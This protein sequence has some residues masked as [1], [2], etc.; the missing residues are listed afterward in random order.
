MFFSSIWILEFI[1][2]SAKWIVGM[3]SLNKSIDLFSANMFSHKL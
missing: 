3:E 2:M 1:H